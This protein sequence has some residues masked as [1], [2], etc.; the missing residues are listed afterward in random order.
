MKHAE[1]M[2]CVEVVSSVAEILI[3][4]VI[5]EGVR[6]E[7][8]TVCGWKRR[9]NTAFWLEEELQPGPMDRGVIEAGARALCTMLL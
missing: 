6:K 8:S 7:N 4:A 2:W 1:N 3:L 9:I 5:C